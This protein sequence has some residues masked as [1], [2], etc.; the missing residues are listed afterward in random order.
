MSERNVFGP[1]LC[2]TRTELWRFE[3]ESF[4]QANGSGDLHALF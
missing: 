3:G 2:V 1:A 4:F